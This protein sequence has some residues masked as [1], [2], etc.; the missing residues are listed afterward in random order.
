MIKAINFFLA[1]GLLLL[2]V[3]QKDI[4]VQILFS[5]IALCNFMIATAEYI[6]EEIKNKAP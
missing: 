6:I 1:L 3:I 2:G 5:C 4:S